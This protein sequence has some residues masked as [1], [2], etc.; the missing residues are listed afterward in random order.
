[1]GTRSTSLIWEYSS[2][3]EDYI[4]PPRKARFDG[5]RNF[6]LAWESV[7]DVMLEMWNEMI[8]N[9]VEDQS[10]RDDMESLEYLMI[11]LIYGSLSWQ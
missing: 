4:S 10:R 8:A 3:E 7:S 11:Y 1:M 2:V 9:Y 5:Y 6:S